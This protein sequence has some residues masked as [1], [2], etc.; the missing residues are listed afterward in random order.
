MS[1][2]ITYLVW[3]FLGLG[4][5]LA[6]P[7]EQ[8]ADHPTAG[9]GP[10]PYSLQIQVEEVDT[11]YYVWDIFQ[12]P[13]GVAVNPC[14][15]TR[16]EKVY[17]GEP[18]WHTNKPDMD[19][20]PY[21][22]NYLPFVPEFEVPIEYG[23]RGDCAYHATGKDAGQFRCGDYYIIDCAKDPRYGQQVSCGNP[24]PRYAVA[25]YCEF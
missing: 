7:A 6:A 9:Q 2:L 10:Y 3:L 14:G 11:K 12:G 20:P 18:G 22:Q 5:V 21:P 8:F 4:F 24:R 15:D 25:W 19:S 16:F 13:S 23:N 17:H 1:S